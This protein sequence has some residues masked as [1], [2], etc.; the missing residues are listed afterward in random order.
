VNFFEMIDDLINKGSNRWEEVEKHYSTLKRGIEDNTQI[1]EK[2]LA[3][4]LVL[5]VD[6]LRPMNPSKEAVEKAG[7]DIKKMLGEK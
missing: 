6:H 4:L 1:S 3:I 5:L 2:D 7:E